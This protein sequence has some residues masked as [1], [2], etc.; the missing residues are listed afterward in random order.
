MLALI[1]PSIALFT[2]AIYVNAQR[3]DAVGALVLSL[4]VCALGALGSGIVT[5]EVRDNNAR[6]LRNR[7][8]K[9]HSAQVLELSNAIV[10]LETHNDN[11]ARKYSAL[12]IDNTATELLNKQLSTIARDMNKSRIT[13]NAEHRQQRAQID[14]LTLS[15]ETLTEQNRDTVARFAH[16]RELLAETGLD[17]VEHEQ[18]DTYT[19]KL[20]ILKSALYHFGWALVEDSDLYESAKFALLSIHADKLTETTSAQ[21]FADYVLDIYADDVEPTAVIPATLEYTYSAST[22]LLIGTLD[23]AY[24]LA[25]GETVYPLG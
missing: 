23:K 18:A 24:N 8:H 19:D 20:R 25:N 6:V 11:Y 14:A 2:W 12:V 21:V 15:L 17:L 1:V 10:K 4:T 5:S 7:L 9:L 13:A 3:V 16:A 22:A